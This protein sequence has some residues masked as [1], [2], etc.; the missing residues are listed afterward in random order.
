MPHLRSLAAGVVLGLALPALPAA[1]LTPAP[2][3]SHIGA[4]SVVP[5]RPDAAPNAA[6]KRMPKLV[7]RKRVRGLSNPW[8]VKT[9]GGGRL[10]VT[11]RDSARLLIVGKGGKRRVRFP[12]RKVW[13]S[14]E[15]GLMSLEVDPGFERNRRIYTCQG[16]RTGARHDI[17][18]VAWRLSK[19]GGKAK[20]LRTLVRGLPTT[21]GRHGGCRLLI[22][23]DG[24]M[25][26]GTGDAAQGKNPRNLRSLGGK[27][28]RLNRF[29]GAPWRTNPFYGGSGNR[30]YVLTYGHR[31]VQGLAQ[32]QDG[33]L[34]SVEHGPD[35]D[36]EVNRLIAG[37]DYG[38]QPTPGYNES[39]PMTDFKL[40]GRQRAAK[41][42][43]GR[44]TLATSGALWVT[45]RKWGALDGTLAVAALKTQKVLFMSFSK[46]GK[47]QRVR[48]PRELRR[49]G[50]LRSISRAGNGDLLITT[51]TDNRG[52]AVL[53]VRPRR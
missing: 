10:L 14:G 52:G 42:R 27:T 39:V 11:E 13:V 17:R 47:L 2:P 49:Y 1:A 36:D 21:S 25:L 18:V 33:T 31:N 15:T 46:S 44:P 40:P 41:W 9:I 30:R 34:W 8:D 37:G 23:K 12:S 3:N 4:P 16:W 35:R 5:E 43:S 29:S 26:V 19:S 45:G 48:V 20:R 28:L 22:A 50:R 38:W 24:S 7:V 6:R 53:R 32:R 51:D